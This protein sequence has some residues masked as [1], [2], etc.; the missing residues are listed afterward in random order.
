MDVKTLFIDSV[1]DDAAT[2][3]SP[4]PSSHNVN[5]TIIRTGIRTRALMKPVKPVL[6]NWLIK[7]RTQWLVPS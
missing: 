2:K 1:K 3:G 7:Q 6:A 5:F 4:Q